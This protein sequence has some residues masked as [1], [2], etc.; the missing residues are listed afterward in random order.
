MCIWM[1]PPRGCLFT[2]RIEGKVLKHPVT[3]YVDG[4]AWMLEPEESRRVSGLWWRCPLVVCLRLTWIN[5]RCTPGFQKI[6]PNKLPDIHG[7]EKGRRERERERRGRGF[8]PVKLH[9]GSSDRAFEQGFE[10][11]IGPQWKH[12]SPGS[13][14]WYQL[15]IFIKDLH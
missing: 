9:S 11:Q 1:C 12:F 6:Y 4:P 5:C 13:S 14:R 7:R 2:M 8:L 3:G 10:I 15:N